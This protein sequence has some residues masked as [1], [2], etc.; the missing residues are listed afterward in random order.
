[1]FSLFK[2]IHFIYLFIFFTVKGFV[3][4]A[5]IVVLRDF[6]IKM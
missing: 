6:V 4:P 3:W 5:A 2:A 1:M